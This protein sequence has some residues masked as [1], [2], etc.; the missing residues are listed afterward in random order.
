MEGKTNPKLAES[1]NQL[2]SGGATWRS[3]PPRQS[4]YRTNLLFHC[5]DAH[6]KH[7][8]VPDFSTGETWERLHGALHAAGDFGS[9]GEHTHGT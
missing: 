4:A 8:V 6:G 1:F 9:K 5:S 3:S 2:S 7:G